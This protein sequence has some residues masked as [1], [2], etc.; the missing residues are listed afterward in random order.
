MLGSMRLLFATDG[1]RGADI[2]LDFLGALPL[3]NADHVLVLTVPTYSFVG[4]NGVRA[5]PAGPS[6]GHGEGAARATAERA[7]SRLAGR[8]SPIAVEIEEGP[9]ARAIEAAAMRNASE[10]VVVGSRGLGVLG[11]RILGSVARQLAR[12]VTL[13]LLVVREQREA[14]RRILLAVDGSEQS[15]AAVALLARLPLPS[16]AR[17][18]LVRV[19]GTPSQTVALRGSSIA[20]CKS[21]TGSRSTA[22]SLFEATP[23]RRSWRRPAQAGP[24]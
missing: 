20:R 21:S 7:R 6:V 12:E 10:L 17:V 22:T 19:S 15:G 14:P 4:E 1:S 3:S 2:A 11:G 18:T 24:I 23:Q 8:G 13:P 5:Q 9:V 16:A